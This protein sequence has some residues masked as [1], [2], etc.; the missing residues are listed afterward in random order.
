MGA[1]GGAYF[2]PRV[3]PDGRRIAVTVR[4]GEHDDVWPY[5]VARET[6]SPKSLKDIKFLRLSVTRLLQ[7]VGDEVRCSRWAVQVFDNWIDRV[8]AISA[9]DRPRPH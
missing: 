3:S 4:G 5:D 1:S 8:R 9:D 7:V 6:W 2:Q